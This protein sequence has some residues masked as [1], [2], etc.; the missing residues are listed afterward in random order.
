MARDFS[1]YSRAAARSPSSCASMARL[2]ST[3]ATYGWSGSGEE[4]TPSARSSA[5]RAF[6]NSPRS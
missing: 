6:L 3:T 5:C 2:L 4:Y 1:K